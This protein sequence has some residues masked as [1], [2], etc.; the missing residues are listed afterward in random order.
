MLTTDEIRWFFP[1]LIPDAVVDWFGAAPVVPTPKRTDIYLPLPSSLAL[2]IKLRQG[3]FEIKTRTS[4]PRPVSYPH[5]TSGMAARWK[6]ESYRTPLVASLEARLNDLAALHVVKERHLRKFS[7]G[8]DS[9][10]EIGPGDAPMLGCLFE[11]T[12][13]WCNGH[14]SWTVALEA[15]GAMEGLEGV[16]DRVAQTVFNASPCPVRLDTKTCADY[17]DWLPT[18]RPASEATTAG[19]RRS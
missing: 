13:L 16:L 18:Q 19:S 6:K 4:A 1:G 17:P 5:S 15:F 2:G 3:R 9:V 8:Q 12:Q 10:T 14:A 11:M 7:L